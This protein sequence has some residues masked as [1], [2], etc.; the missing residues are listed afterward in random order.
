MEGLSEPR[1]HTYTMIEEWKSAEH[2]QNHLKQPHVGE[3]LGLL[4]EHGV[5]FDGRLYEKA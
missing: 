5:K 4:K 3:L 1:K 2:L